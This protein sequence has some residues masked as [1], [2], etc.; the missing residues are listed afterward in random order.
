LVEQVAVV[1]SVLI[2]ASRLVLQHTV[3]VL[4]VHLGPLVRE[5]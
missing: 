2:I 5:Q 3:V 4:E 1:V